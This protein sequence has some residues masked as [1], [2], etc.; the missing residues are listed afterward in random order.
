MHVVVHIIILFIFVFALLM[1]NIPR[2]EHDSY[3]KMK[4]Y[5]F[6]SIFLFEMIIS[7]FISIY[8]KCIVN[9]GKIAKQSLLSALVATVAYS[10]YNDMVFMNEPFLLNQESNL[11]RNLTITVIITAFI[12]LSYFIEIIF[13]NTIPNVNDCLNTIY[14]DKKS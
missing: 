7:I 5:I 9:I 11:T 8:K 14:P 2:I 10:I 1:L 3:I 4:L 6:T 12:A 13:T